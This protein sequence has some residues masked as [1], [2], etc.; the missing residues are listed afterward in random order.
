[1]KTDSACY[2]FVCA[3]ICTHLY[4]EFSGLAAQL[5]TVGIKIICN[6]GETKINGIM[7]QRNLNYPAKAWY[8]SKYIDCKALPSFL[9]KLHLKVTWWCC[10]SLWQMSSFYWKPKWTQLLLFSRTVMFIMSL[11][12]VPK[13]HLP[14]S[15]HGMMCTC[16]STQTDCEQ[17]DVT[18]KPHSHQVKEEVEQNWPLQ[19]FFPFW[20]L[21]RY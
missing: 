11:D 17:P 14:T 9:W 2:K 7:I 8:T 5:Q 12:T 16:A 10:S 20:F 21:S 1:M 19:V 3:F 18:V 4:S 15:S 6:F 13:N